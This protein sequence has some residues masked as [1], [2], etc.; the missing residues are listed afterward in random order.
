[1]QHTIPIDQIGM[2]QAEEMA[3]AISACVH[4]GF[5][6]ATCPPYLV[7]GEEMDSP[8]GRIVLMRDVL[9]GKLPLEQAQPHI[10]RC[11]GCVACVTACPVGA[12]FRVDPVKAFGD[13]NAVFA[14][15][16]AGGPL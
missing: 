10:D 8:R 6:L 9:E 1:M 2:P 16:A 3:H 11:L 5:C 14:N 15:D 7:M 13:L 4:C 12:A